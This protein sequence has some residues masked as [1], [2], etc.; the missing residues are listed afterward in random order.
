[1]KVKIMVTVFLTSLI[2]IQPVCTMYTQDYWPTVEWM[3]STPEEFGMDSSILAGVYNYIERNNLE[4]HSVLIIK[5]GYII[6]ESYPHPSYDQDTT[7]IIYSC[8]K[9]ITSA[10]IGIA[11]REGFLT[12]I[13]Q[14]IMDIFPDREIANLDAHKQSLTI[15][16]LLTMTSGLE[17]NEWPGW[18]AYSDPANTYRS[19]VVSDDWVQFVLDRPMVKEPGEEF[20]YNTAVSHLLSAIIQQVTGITTLEYAQQHLFEPLGISK[21]NWPTDPQGVYEGGSSLA[22]TPRDMAKFGYLYL[23]KG[24]WDGEQI[25]PSDWVEESTIGHVSAKSH[26]TGCDYGYQ[27]W[28]YPNLDMYAGL[29]YAGQQIFVLP[30]YNIVIVFTGN[31]PSFVRHYIRLISDYIIPA[32]KMEL[33][34]LAE[35]LPVLIIFIIPGTLTMIIYRRKM[36][37]FH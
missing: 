31:N 23:N 4:M 17:W 12:G 18:V 19:W 30:D 26:I 25:V 6:E 29:G 22:L 8:T 37:R 21:L 33:N 15:E 20:N 11:I 27:W 10:L 13:D 28:I 2:A 9:S 7:H 32:E 34:E 24:V 14:R 35:P 3:R 36:H 1:M 5:D 16:H